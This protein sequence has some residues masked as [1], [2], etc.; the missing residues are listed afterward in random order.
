MLALVVAAIGLYGVISYGVAQR[1]REMGVRIALGANRRDIVWLVTRQGL[2]VATAGV[3]LGVGLALVF[4]GQVP[5]LLF[6]QSAKDPGVYAIAGGVLV[7][8]AVIATLLPA[9]R[10]SRANPTEALRGE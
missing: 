7:R 5:P 1:R 6:S 8:V 4:S 3:L 10:A 2:A 9:T